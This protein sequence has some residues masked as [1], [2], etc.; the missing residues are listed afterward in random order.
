M[1][2]GNSTTNLIVGGPILL[3]H[4]CDTYD[5]QMYLPIQCKYCIDLSILEQLFPQKN[6]HFLPKYKYLDRHP[7][8]SNLGVE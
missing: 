2:T 1:D 8:V 6:L 4:T 3:N 7:M 5:S